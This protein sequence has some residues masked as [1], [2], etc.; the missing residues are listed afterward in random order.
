M[1]R[2]SGKKREEREK[3]GRGDLR[4]GHGIEEGGGRKWK[5]KKRERERIFL[6]G[7]EDEWWRRDVR[8]AFC[9]LFPPFVL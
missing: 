2:V 6:V 5:Q 3:E 9:L 7:E 4:I 1:P 8:E